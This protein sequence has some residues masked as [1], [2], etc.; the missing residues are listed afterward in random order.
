MNSNDS[1][2]A[3]ILI[4]GYFSYIYD[5][6]ELLNGN[7]ILLCISTIEDGTGDG[8][9]SVIEITN[10]GEIKSF[11]LVKYMGVENI[12]SAGKDSRVVNMDV[13]STDDGG[14]TMLLSNRDVKNAIIVHFSEDGQRAW[15]RVLDYSIDK[16]NYHNPKLILVKDNDDN[17]YVST[18][19]NRSIIKISK[20]GDIKWQRS[21]DFYIFGIDIINNELY[22][23]ARSTETISVPKVYFSISGETNDVSYL[24]GYALTAKADKSNG[25]LIW[26]SKIDTFELVENYSTVTDEKGNIYSYGIINEHRGYKEIIV[27]YNKDGKRIGEIILGNDNY[28]QP[29]TSGYGYPSLDIDDN[30]IKLVS[31]HEESYRSIKLSEVEWEK[32][33]MVNYDYTIFYQNYLQVRFVLNIILVGTLIGVLG[34]GAFIK[35]NNREA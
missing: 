31:V 29:L 21:Y 27:K 13:V 17:Y 15:E 10:Q 28:R 3:G 6:D 26:D 14:Y 25:K 7:I 34:Y 33:N 32:G 19:Y 5:A 1:S 23:S 8:H 18:K 9:F 30:T 11:N 12:I 16:K 22:I 24:N 4:D 35:H 2:E 20:S